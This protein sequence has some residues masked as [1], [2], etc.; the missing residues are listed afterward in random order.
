VADGEPGVR[1]AIELL[2]SE[3]SRDMALLG[4]S[5]LAEM[6]SSLIAQNH[7]DT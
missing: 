1:R 6:N 7:R 4:I 2:S 5:D 3:I